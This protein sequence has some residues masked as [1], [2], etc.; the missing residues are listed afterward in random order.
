ME[1]SNI[2]DRADRDE[3]LLKSTLRI[4]LALSCLFAFAVLCVGLFQPL[5]DSYSFRQTQT[6]L[7]AYW[8]QRGGPVFA[9]E[10]PVAGYPWAIPFEFP[11]YQIIVAL[12]NTSGVPLDAAGR[13]V[14]FIFFFSCLW[15]MHVLF[16]AMR[17]GDIAFLCIAIMFLLA[18]LYVF[19][20]RTF[21]IETCA[22]FFSLCWLSYIARYLKEPKTVFALLAVITGTLGILTKATTFPAFAVLGG[23]LILKD[24][25]SIWT[26]RTAIN[27]LRPVL[28]AIFTLIVPFFIEILWTFYSD[29]VRVKNEFGA[30]WTG[31]RLTQWTVGTWDQRVSPELWGVITLRSAF[32]TFGYG[33][34]PA[35]AV[36]GVALSRRKYAYVTL[37]AI[38]AYLIPFL[39]FTNVHILHR[40]Y[41]TAN[42]IFLI[43]ASGFGIASATTAK[44]PGLAFVCLTF[45]VAGQLLGFWATYANLITRDVSDDTLLGPI[46]IIA[47]L[48][49]QVTKPN[50]SLIVI[51]DTWSSRVPYYAQRKSFVLP[52]SMPTS[53]WKRILAAPQKFLGDAQLG[54]IIYCANTAPQDTDRKALVD[55]FIADRAVMADAGRCQLLAP[56]KG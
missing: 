12:L 11:V 23:L 17:L 27:K 46:F 47:N 38:L 5:L 43:A 44:R 14:S 31:R 32:D 6:A 40:Y 34:V 3:R 21:M 1:A 30:Q 33:L 28:L 24:S 53:S 37:A 50:T 4:I 54:G 55:D 15:P 8:L 41:Q 45:I 39:V 51:G 10:T 29:T 13:I 48:T 35:I 20:G 7:T 42:A 9:Y 18:P 36:I 2:T 19:W 56:A 49:K 25:Y 26:D 22:L 16:R 52:E